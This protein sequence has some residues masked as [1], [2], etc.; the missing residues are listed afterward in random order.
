MSTATLFTGAALLAAK[1]DGAWFFN[2]AIT[3]KLGPAALE[4]FGMLLVSGLITIVVGLFLGLR[5]CLMK[6]PLWW[7]AP[8]CSSASSSQSFC[9]CRKSASSSP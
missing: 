4:T 2:P 3:R 1:S 9:R 8:R 5:P 7:S 6:L